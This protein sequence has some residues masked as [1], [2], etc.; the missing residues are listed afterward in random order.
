MPARAATFSQRCSAAVC[1]K[2]S[3]A[4]A[5]FTEQGKTM[6]AICAMRRCVCP[7]APNASRVAWKVSAHT[8]RAARKFVCV[9]GMQ[10]AA[11]HTEKS[12]RTCMDRAPSASLTCERI[13]NVT[14]KILALL[15][16]TILGNGAAA[17]DSAATP[18]SAAAP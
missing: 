1:A 15:L 12:P 8:V 14:G 13:M 7:I 2:N 17:A 3:L 9:R 18:D 16:L 5:N 4:H 11:E 6:H 10:L